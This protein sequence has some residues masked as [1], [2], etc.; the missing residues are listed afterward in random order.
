MPNRT[1]LSPRGIRPTAGFHVRIGDPMILLDG[2][3]LTL[4][5]LLAI[6]DDR[7]RG[8]AGA[9]RRG[10]RQ[11]RARGRGCQGRRRRGG[12]RHQHR[13]RLVRRSDDPARLARRLQLNLLRSHAAGVGEPL[14]VRAVRAMMAL[15][16]N[17]LARGFSGIRLETLEALLAAL[18]RGVH[19]GSR[20]ADR[21][22]RAATSRRSPT[23]RSC[24][25]ARARRGTARVERPGAEAL[26]AAGLAPVRLAAKGRPRP[27]QRHAGLHRRPRARARR[28]GAPGARRR[29]RRRALDRRAARVVAPV[30]R[31]HPRRAA[32][33][34]PGGVGRQHRARCS[35]AAPST[36]RT[37]TAGASRTPTPSAARRRCTA[38]PARRSLHP[39]R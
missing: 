3:S 7:S 27:H 1:I 26:R 38:R 35:T 31:A 18:N 33:P 24:S 9:R 13:L 14:P 34:R 29:R 39:R 6:A 2:R 19:P 10:A 28:R 21:S 23:W 25:S 20:A 37:P 8:R 5:Q 11:R 4:E 16:A 22:A 12:L 36:P 17:V 15:R 32:A 30:R